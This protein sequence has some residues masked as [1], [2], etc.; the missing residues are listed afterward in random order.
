MVEFRS[1]VNHPLPVNLGGKESISVAA[2][3]VFECTPE[4]ARSRGVMREVLANRIKMVSMKSVV[5]LPVQPIV[6]T[7]LVDNIAPTTEGD[8]SFSSEIEDHD[9]IFLSDEINH[10]EGIVDVFKKDDDSLTYST[11]VVQSEEEKAS[12]EEPK[13]KHRKRKSNNS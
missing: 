1:R 5:S 10:E 7:V 8:S 11:E 13:R 6:D 4:Q 9:H 12:D 3:G 2:K